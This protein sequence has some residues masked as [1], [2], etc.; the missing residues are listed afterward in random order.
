V[1]SRTPFF[2]KLAAEIN[3]AC[4]RKLFEEMRPIIVIAEVRKPPLV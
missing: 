1:E 3:I 2:G 4:C